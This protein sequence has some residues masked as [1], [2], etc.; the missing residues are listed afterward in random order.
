MLR[1]VVAGS[2]AMLL[3]VMGT[4]TLVAYVRTAEARALADE[5]LVDVLVLTTAVD[6]GTPVDDLGSAVRT[7]RVPIK[8]RA[9]GAVGE[10]DELDGLV[11]ATDLLEGEQVVR[12]RFVSPEAF[13]TAP[14]PD[15]LQSVTIRLAPERA[16]GGLLHPGDTV[17]VV[18]SFVASSGDGASSSSRLILQ[19]VLVTGVQRP[20]SRTIVPGASSGETSDRS[21]VPEA[22]LLVTLALDADAAQ[23]LIFAAEHGSIWLS[24]Q[25]D[26]AAASSPQAVTIQD[27]TP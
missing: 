7:E 12:A 15:G 1:R 18:A 6:A 11:A 8:V 10:L 21:L 14:L 2:V 26:T 24:G 20:S 23:R 19:Q 17:G 22:D 16:L 9:G 3:A 25:P 5:E 4:L 27:L 13:G